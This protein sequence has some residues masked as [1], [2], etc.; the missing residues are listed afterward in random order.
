[1]ACEVPVISTNTGG[2]PEINIQGET[3]YLSNVGDVDNMAQN[4]IALLQ[5]EE[6]L[7]RFKQQAYEQAR[8]FSLDKIMPLYEA[9]Y[10][11]VLERSAAKV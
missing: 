11:K 9:Y 2:V 1:M 3:G 10:Q 7:A 6:K 5:D 4:A 8:R